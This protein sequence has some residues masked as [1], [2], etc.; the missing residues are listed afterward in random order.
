MNVLAY[1]RNTVRVI[2]IGAGLIGVTTAYF[3]Q[4]RGHEVIVLD[5]E[6]GPGLDTSFANAGLLTPSM[7]DPWNTP[8]CWRHLLASLGQSDAA[9]QLRL[10]TLPSLAKWGIQFLRNSNVATFERSALSNLHLALYSLRVMQ[11]LRE[12]TGIEYG[13]SARGS[14]RIFRSQSACDKALA[15]AERRA[16]AGLRFRRLSVAQTLEMEPALGPIGDRLAGAIHYRDDE[17]GDA[18]RFC[19]ALA[20]YA[21]QQGVEFRFS[22]SVSSLEMHSR[23]VAAAISG[24]ERL[25]ADRYIVAAGS[26]STPLLRSVG[27]HL[28]IQPAKGYS[29]TARLRLLQPSPRI[30]VIDDDL[31]AAIVPFEGAIRVAGTAELCGYD[32]ALDPRRVRNLRKLLREV[33]PQALLD[34]QTLTAWCGFRA[35]SADGV[36]II[37]S[38]PVSNL[39]VNTGHGHLGWTMAA[40]SGQ[41]LEQILCG[42]ST[43]I[44]AEPF[45]LSR[46]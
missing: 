2:V 5:R 34:L 40:G 4:D 42:E 43:G 31:H 15:T 18:Y 17:T 28:P 6:K 19:V 3:L 35:M 36:P 39:Y 9:L 14:L 38:T 30:P 21:Q 10:R 33:L 16:G 29:L 37:G 22:T 46:F 7:S 11:S 27:V 45:A 13:Q 8:G 32:R 26:Y 20:A 25:F 44:D 23:Q 41:L 24:G 12:R 1:G